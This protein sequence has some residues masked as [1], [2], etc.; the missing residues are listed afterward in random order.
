MNST[1][2]NSDGTVSVTT[3]GVDDDIN[4]TLGL[5]GRTYIG[6]ISSNSVKNKEEGLLIKSEF[7]FDS[8]S[9]LDRDTIEV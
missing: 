3:T 7:T 4:L 1:E 9:S 6:A 5:N 2:D 8:I